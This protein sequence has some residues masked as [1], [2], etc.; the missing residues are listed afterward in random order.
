MKYNRVGKTNIFLS[1]I[2][3]GTCQLRLVPENQAVD[4]LKRGFQLG[5]NWVH[6]SPDYE[7]TEKII[8][9]AIEKTDKEIIIL[10]NGYGDIPHFEYLFEKTCE[11]FK[12]Q[13]LEM[14][15]I[16]CIDDREYLGE[17]VWGKDGMIEFLLKKKRNGRLNGIFCSTHGT[18][19]YV[20]K[21][22]KSKYF[23]TIMLSYNPLGFHLLSYYP[24]DRQ[25]ENI[26]KNR[27]EIFNYAYKKNVGL[28]IMKPLA[29]G[30]L[31]RS[32]AF[33][34]Y[35]RFT[36]EEKELSSTSILKYILNI[37][38]VCSVVP[39]T[40][41]V[42][43]AEENAKAGYIP[44]EITKKEKLEIEEVAEEMK[45]MLCSRCGYCDEL[46]SKHLPISW[47]IRDGYISTYPSET[48]ETIDRLQYFHLH[49]GKQLACISCNDK[50][51]LCPNGIDIP[52]HLEKIHKQ[53]SKLRDQGLISYTYDMQKVNTISGRY[54]VNIIRSIVPSSLK[55]GEKS[56]CRLWL[57]NSGIIKW[58][59]SNF[60]DKNNIISLSVYIDKHFKRKV[61]LRHDVEPGQ[62]THFAFEI[63]APK[64]RGIYKIKFY[65]TSRF[66]GKKNK[67][68]LLI[69]TKKIY[70]SKN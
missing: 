37:P 11:L 15:G 60:R 52:A 23:D 51:C 28:L 29:G 20:Y 36:N 58:N 39:G 44:I 35:E 16:A 64:K 41:S 53:M 34:P 26:E 25:F 48:F 67:D 17:N 59:S 21:L 65:L 8:L 38:S 18:S 6:T 13:R 61:P 30:L 54:V 24:E 31:C 42:E 40:A 47:M 33:P 27:K 50:S 22:I 55:A 63:N 3:M 14:F 43:E 66:D 1:A 19:E 46:C 2:G 10:S 68:S 49:P 7:G 12:K 32:K 45:K 69:Y 4:T 9:R 5:I 56:V 62:R 57:Q 70:I